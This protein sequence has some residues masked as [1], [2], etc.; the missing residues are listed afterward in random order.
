MPL[1]LLDDHLPTAPTRPFSLTSSL[2]SRLGN[3]NSPS[4][5]MA[6]S[7]TTEDSRIE[8]ASFEKMVLKLSRPLSN[9]VHTA[10]TH[11]PNLT[12]YDL[13]TNFT[14]DKEKPSDFRLDRQEHQLATSGG[15][16]PPPSCFFAY[17]DCK[18]YWCEPCEIGFSQKQGFT[19]H[20]KDKHLQRN[21]CP[22]CR[23]FE[24]SPGRLYKLKAHI[25]E[26]HPNAAPPGP[27]FQ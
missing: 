2:P 19:R 13:D 14:H 27:E 17:R 6:I 20:K 24:W 9:E 18:K 12:S 22:Y 16:T 11:L 10:D 23:S 8:A 25:K 5:Y 15:F 4:S 3:Q 1:P 21:I 26:H 7:G